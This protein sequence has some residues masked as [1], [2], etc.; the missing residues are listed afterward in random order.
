MLIKLLNQEKIIS[1]TE[2]ELPDVAILIAA[3]NEEDF[4]AA[5]ICNTMQLDYPSSKLH[6][7][8]VS[9]GSNDRTNAIIGT[10]WKCNLVI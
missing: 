5:K 6:I 9:D 3:Y 1:E 2:E 7:Y 4:I 8:V 10:F